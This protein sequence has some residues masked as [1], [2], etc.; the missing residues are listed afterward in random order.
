[1]FNLAFKD[2]WFCVLYNLNSVYSLYKEKSI[3]ME[4]ELISH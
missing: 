4:N 2:A 3:F 1:M